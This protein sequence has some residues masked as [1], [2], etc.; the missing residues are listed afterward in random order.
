[1]LNV[2]EKLLKEAEEWVTAINKHFKIKRKILVRKGTDKRCEG[3]YARTD[4]F[5]DPK[6]PVVIHLYP[7]KGKKSCPLFNT[8]YH[9]MTHILLWPL[10]QGN[11][12]NGKLDKTEE[13]IVRSLEHIMGKVLKTLDDERNKNENKT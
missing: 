13:K 11:P 6:E 1:M 9:E 4:L 10:T 5:M 12:E 3:Y 7:H 2:D 8:I